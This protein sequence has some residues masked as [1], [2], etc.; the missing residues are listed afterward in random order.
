MLAEE[1]LAGN[2]LSM[3]AEIDRLRSECRFFVS[4]KVE[5]MILRGVGEA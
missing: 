4:E 1:K 5:D 2:L 3:K